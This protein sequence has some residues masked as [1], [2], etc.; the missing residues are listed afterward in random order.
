[1]KVGKKQPSNLVVTQT[2]KSIKITPP[3]FYAPLRHPSRPTIETLITVQSVFIS[4]A[5]RAFQSNSSYLQPDVSYANICDAHR[6]TCPK[7]W[8]WRDSLGDDAVCRQGRKTCNVHLIG[9]ANLFL[10]CKKD[11][12]IWLKLEALTIAV[13]SSS[14]RYIVF[15]NLPYLAG[16]SFP[17]CALLPGSYVA[18]DNY[19]PPKVKLSRC[20]WT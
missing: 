17:P 15:I 14:R 6:A 7:S 5:L 12:K 10:L 8:R 11:S 1:M 3:L 18:G 16:L 20:W 2:I 19:S 13:G 9:L 4:K